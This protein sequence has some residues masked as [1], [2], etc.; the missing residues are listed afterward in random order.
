MTLEFHETLDWSEPR[1]VD[2]RQ[3]LKSVQNATPND[4]FWNAW[5]ENK[6]QVRDVGYSVRKNEEEGIW[7]VAYWSEPNSE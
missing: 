1:T 5:K 2:T 7:E 6:E 4:A 3:G